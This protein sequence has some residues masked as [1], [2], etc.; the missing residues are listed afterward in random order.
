LSEE[1]ASAPRPWI[2][3]VIPYHN[4]EQALPELIRLLS[5]TM[6]ASRRSFEVLLVNDAST[7][8]S[9]ER[10]QQATAG[11]SR[12][13][14]LTLAERGG[15]TGAFKAAFAAARGE[16][17]IRMDADL[18]DDPSDLPLFIEKLDAGYQLIIGF[19]RN[20]QHTLL[21]RVATTVYDFVTS[22]MFRIELHSNSGS[23]IAFKAALMKNIPFRHN[24]HRYLPLI[25]I[26]RGANPV[27]TVDARHGARRYGTS[28][29][30]L[31]RKLLTAAPEV[32]GFYLRYSRGYYDLAEGAATEE[33]GAPEKAIRSVG[34]EAS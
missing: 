10:A 26:R 21:L 2:T 5:T 30:G 6:D 24:D 29:Y 25:A 27:G 23:F 32:L 9:L 22:R 33:G 31:A 16:Y 13:R 3:I 11:D 19:R 8:R 7:D 15:Q 20:R 18:Q 1:N 12:Y 34:K 28:K 4:E 17:L 14:N